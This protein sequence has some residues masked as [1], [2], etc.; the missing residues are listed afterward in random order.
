MHGRMAECLSALLEVFQFNVKT[1]KQETLKIALAREEKITLM[2]TIATKFKFT[3]S[4]IHL[5]WT[6]AA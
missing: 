2:D 5:F 4:V 6:C 3:W 1:L